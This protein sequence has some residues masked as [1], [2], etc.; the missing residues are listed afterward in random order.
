MNVH[1]VTFAT[2]E[3][4]GK[5]NYYA[6]SIKN[7]IDSAKLF[8]IEHFHLYTPDSLPV[9]KYVKEYMEN[10][11]NTGYGFYSWKPIIILDVMNKINDGDIILY[12]DAGRHEYKYEF[13]KDINI[14]IN[15]VIQNYKGIGVPGSLYEHKH[16]CKRDCFINMKCNE[17]R[18]WNLKHLCATWS[19]W[20]KNDLALKFLEEWK[21]YCNDE[22]GTVTTHDSLHGALSDFSDFKEHRWDQAILTNLIEKYSN[23]GIK[24][25]SNNGGW[26]KDING[27]IL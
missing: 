7:L 19:I 18:Y 4:F 13:R 17:P 26:E 27:F 6:N 25:L 22:K 23:D 9:G 24:S 16:W 10:T 11:H 15:T 2:P 5:K 12:H 21:Y 3:K 20:E 1:F 8:G 14:L